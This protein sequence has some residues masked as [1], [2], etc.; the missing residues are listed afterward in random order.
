MTGLSRPR[1]PKSFDVHE[2]ATTDAPIIMAT[3]ELE[4]AR[5]AQVNRNHALL[6]ARPWLLSGRHLGTGLGDRW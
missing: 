5:L 6:E 4:H 3:M 2:Q 1:S